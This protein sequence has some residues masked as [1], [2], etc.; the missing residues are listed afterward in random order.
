VAPP[1]PVMQEL[2]DVPS[3]SPSDTVALTPFPATPSAAAPSTIPP[4]EP[5]TAE[6]QADSGSLADA[7]QKLEV[8]LGDAIRQGQVVVEN[9]QDELAVVIWSNLVF[10]GQTQVAS[11]IQNHLKGIGDIAAMHPDM[12]VQVQAHS[13]SPQGSGVTFQQAQAVA[14]YLRSSS[15]LSNAPTA[16][17]A[18]AN[19]PRFS[20]GSP[21]AQ[22]G[23]NDRVEIILSQR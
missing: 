13:S 11:R 21:E 9:R 8:V 7:R 16:T 17:G 3:F 6:P 4:L 5:R 1:A 18:G 23:A 22:R 20:P 14:D 19:N 10:D 12:S 15:S 2:P